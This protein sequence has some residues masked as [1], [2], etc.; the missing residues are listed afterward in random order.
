M[1]EHSFM[2]AAALA[3]RRADLEGDTPPRFPARNVDLVKERI[4]ALFRRES[5][6]RLVCAAACGADLVALDVAENMGIPAL[7]VLPFS[8]ATFR[9]VSVID[10]PG[11]WG[12]LYDRLVDA[13]ARRADLIT[14]GLAE[15]DE[16]AFTVGNARIISEARRAAEQRLAVAVWEGSSRGEGDATAELLTAGQQQGFQTASVSTL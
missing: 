5:I 11:N 6:D 12:G 16:T 9:R 7:I 15:D 14:L 3:G 8:R 2:K 4:S 1:P 13:A 10:R